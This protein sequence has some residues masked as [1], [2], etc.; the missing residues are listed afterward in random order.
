MGRRKV[1]GIICGQLGSPGHPICCT[2]FPTSEF[3]GLEVGMKSLLYVRSSLVLPVV[4]VFCLA[5]NAQG[6]PGGGGGTG[7]GGTG[8]GG[9]PGGGGRPTGGVSIPTVPNRSAP[10]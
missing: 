8:G 1:A 3:S 9:T 5:A 4:L 6:H 2:R 7:G 10:M